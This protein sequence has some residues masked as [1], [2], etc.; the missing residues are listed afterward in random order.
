MCGPKTTLI[1][2][3]LLSSISLMARRGVDKAIHYDLEN[4]RSTAPHAILLTLSW[5]LA[6]LYGIMIATPSNS[7][8]LR[9]RY[10]RHYFK[11]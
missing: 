7:H 8:S 11:T 2:F 1:V 5:D 3:T 6:I 10:L 9:F 4:I